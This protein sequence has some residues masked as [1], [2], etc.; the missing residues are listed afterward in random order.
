MRFCLFGFLC[1][2]SGSVL[3]DTVLPMAGEAPPAL[4]MDAPPHPQTAESANAPDAAFLDQLLPSVRNVDLLDTGKGAAVINRPLAGDLMITYGAD[5]TA[6][7]TRAVAAASGIA[8]PMLHDIA[9]ENLMQKARDAVI[10]GSD[11]GVYFLA[12]DGEN[13][14][15]LLLDYALW[16]SITQ[17][18]GPIIMSVPAG[19]LVLFVPQDDAA[20]LN[21]LQEVRDSVLANRGDAD[22]LSRQL[23]TWHDDAWVVVP[24]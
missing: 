11:E 10:S 14:N 7:I 2:L 8:P 18:V 22:S 16:R 3:A 4:T 15:A 5:H 20:A 21:I 17:Q 13:E 1:I 24:E 12:L 23:F 9:M 19:D 6:P